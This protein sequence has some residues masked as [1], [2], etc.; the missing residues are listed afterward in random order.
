MDSS[1]NL[2]RSFPALL[3]VRGI[4]RPDGTASL[5]LGPPRSEFRGA[6]NEADSPLRLELWRGDERLL[7]WGATLG[8][9]GHGHH[10]GGVPAAQPLEIHALVPLAPGSE[11]LVA[12]LHDRPVAE[13]ALPAEAPEIEGLDATEEDEHV[14]L[15]WSIRSPSEAKL[16]FDIRASA[17]R[18]K[19]WTRLATALRER[20][21][22]IPRARLPGGDVVIQVLASDGVHRVAAS[23]GVVLPERDDLEVIVLSPVGTRP[24]PADRP[25]PL[26]ALAFHPG[27]PDPVEDAAV[28][29]HVG[30][31]A[32]ARGRTARWADPP[33][34]E[35]V[36]EARV[37]TD[38]SRGSA[39]RKVTVR[40][41]P[42][43]TIGHAQP[44]PESEEGEEEATPG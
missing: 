28:T 9:P 2:G 20:S 41:V 10:T 36:L 44:M 3:R 17:N 6:H 32:V 38:R 19:S 4:L 30:E 27:R 40:A 18:G 35:H 22:R 24:H 39:R 1:G 21:S 26:R 42:A 11:R 43:P 5:R 33:E 31:Q 8:M 14:L 16:G 34:G 29:W 7:D 12:R 23:T 25:M 15:R 37:R 13:L